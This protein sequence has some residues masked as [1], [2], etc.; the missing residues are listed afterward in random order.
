MF[1]ANTDRKKDA[2]AS[3]ISRYFPTLAPP[4]LK[5][6][7]LYLTLLPGAYTVQTSGEGGGEGVVLTEV[8]DADLP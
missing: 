7:A 3:V 6:A 2:N 1:A 8:Y 5:E 4:G